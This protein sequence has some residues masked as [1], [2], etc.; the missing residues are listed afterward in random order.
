MALPVT[1]SRPGGI[2]F[3]RSANI[4]VCRSGRDLLWLPQFEASPGYE[5]VGVLSPIKEVGGAASNRRLAGIILF[6]YPT[7]SSAT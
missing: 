3:T 6:R 5:C 1:Q 7:E 2:L 4:G